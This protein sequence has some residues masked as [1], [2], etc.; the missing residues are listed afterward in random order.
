MTPSSRKAMMGKDRH[1][2]PPI[3]QADWSE[4][5]M[6]RVLWDEYLDECWPGGLHSPDKKFVPPDGTPPVAL[7][8][9]L[10]LPNQKHRHGND[11]RYEQIE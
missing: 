11:D 1:A 9:A 8:F 6:E 3:A 4:S 2:M 7:V 10:R 5:E